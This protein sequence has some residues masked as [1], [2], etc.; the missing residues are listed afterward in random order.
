M[1]PT[2]VL[3]REQAE[4]RIQAL[5]DA[6]LRILIKEGFIYEETGRTQDS[7]FALCRRLGPGYTSDGV[8][9]LTRKEAARRWAL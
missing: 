7:I 6:D 1:P 5:L 3:Y 4:I 8:I 9:L 2:Q